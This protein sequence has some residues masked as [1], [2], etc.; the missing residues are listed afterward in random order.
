MGETFVEIILPK[1]AVVRDLPFQLD[2]RV[3]GSI[4]GVSDLYNN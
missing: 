4:V 1:E 2:I 3:D